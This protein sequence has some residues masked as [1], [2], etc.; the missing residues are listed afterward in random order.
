M[1]APVA[2]LLRAGVERGDWSGL[3]ERLADDA[4]LRTSSEAGRIRVDG[5]AAIVAHLGR[6]GPGEVRLW[7]AREWPAG[8]ALSFEWC[9][10]GALL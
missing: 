1:T 8:V 9:G 4:V 2:P 5:P 7:E 3:G 6:P 10:A